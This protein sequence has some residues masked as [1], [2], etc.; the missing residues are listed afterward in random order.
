MPRQPAAHL[1]L[2]TT[3][4]SRRADNC[5]K[6]KKNIFLLVLMRNATSSLAPGN[7]AE[8]ELKPTCHF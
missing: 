5:G 2:L 3:P 4:F 7:N 8:T 6:P 1:H